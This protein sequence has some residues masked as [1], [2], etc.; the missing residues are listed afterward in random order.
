MLDVACGTGLL[1]KW[2]IERVP[3]IEA[4]GIDASAD[5]LAQARVVLSGQPRDCMSP[6]KRRSLWTGC[7]MA[8][9]YAPMRNL[10]KR[11]KMRTEHEL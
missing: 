2:V 7:G 10:L 9:C 1:L 5:M 6:V 8:G 3:A 4:H 11:A